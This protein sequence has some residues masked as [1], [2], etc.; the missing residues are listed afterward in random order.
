MS[1]VREFN[2]GQLSAVNSTTIPLAAGAKFTGG[3][4]DVSEFVEVRIAIFSDQDSAVGG[5][6]IE[7][8][9]D[10]TNWDHTDDYD[11]PANTGKNY[12]V[13]RVAQ[14]Y[15][16]TYIN[17]G[18]IQ[19][20]FRLSSIFNR[21]AGVPS[22]HNVSDSISPEDDAMLTKTVLTGFNQD[23][24]LFQNIES[25]DDGVL[26]ISNQSDGLAISEGIVQGKGYE[27]KFGAAGG[28]NSA[29]PLVDLWDGKTVEG[30]NSYTY[31]TTADIDSLSSSSA[32]DTQSIVVTGLDAN[33]EEL[34]Q[35]V[36]LTGQAR[37]AIP[38]PFIRL[39]RMYNDD[40]TDFAGDVYGYVNGAITAGVPNVLADIRAVIA[41]GNNQTLMVV[42]TIP[43]GKTGYVR[44]FT[45]KPGQSNTKTTTN[46]GIRSGAY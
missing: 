38:I 37:V 8:S 2:N 26:K 43:A 18:T 30:I 16:L 10:G 21:V 25:I 36:I 28:I 12:V 23:T 29:D 20:E 1:R 19:T 46:A 41:V 7:F 4:E 17:G 44:N 32:G 22:S 45:W 27:H 31:S 34:T 35:T 9:V 39:F 33:F 40:T 24:G 15:R 14:F 13:Q 6:S 3:V 42:Y 5:L 11:V